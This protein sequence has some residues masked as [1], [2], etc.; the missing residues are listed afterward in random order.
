MWNEISTVIP[1]APTQQIGDNISDRADIWDAGEPPEQTW[2]P[3]PAGGWDFDKQSQVR[4]T[5]IYN[6]DSPLI[7]PAIW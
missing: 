6:L 7:F 5:F 3:N 4:N 2:T 1:P